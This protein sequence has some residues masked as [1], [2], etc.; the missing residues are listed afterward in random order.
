M[1]K[2]LTTLSALNAKLELRDGKLRVNAPAGV[3]TP[4]LQK[5]IARHKDALIAR[6]QA[7]PEIAEEDELPRIVPDP[8]RRFEPFP[9]NGV[10]HAYWIGRSSHIELGSVSTHVYF[11][12]ECAP[13][14]PAR[15]TAALRK[16]VAAHDMLRAVV[17]E[18][19]EQCVLRDVPEYAIDVTDVRDADAARREAELLRVRGEMAHQV[20]PSDRWPLF[21]VRL[22]QV[23]ESHSR[24]CV[25]WDFLVVDAWSMMLIFR[26]WFALYQDAAYDVPVPAL[27]FRDY[28]LAEAGLKELPAYQRSKKY[29]WDRIDALPE[30]PQL[31]VHHKI[32]LGRKHE[33]TR[34]RLR[35]DA[36][37]WDELKARGRK[38]GLT[39]TSVLLGVF[40]EVLNR[41]TKVPHYCLNL[42]LFNRLPMHDDVGGLVGDFT[43]LLALEIDGREAGSFIERAARIQSQF[44]GDFEHRQVSAVD[45]M[46]DVVKRRGLQQ[47][48]VLPVVFTSTL[49]L[50]GKRSDDASVLESFGPMGY[51]IGQTPQVW[52]D[53]QIFEIKG[54]L[55]INWDAV[56]E[57]FLPGVLDD[58]FESHR[59]L[60]D[61]L[62]ADAALWEQRD[63]LQLPE[64]QR[65]LREQ[66]D[67]TAAEVVDCCLHAPFVAQ[68][69]ATPERIAIESAAGAM[70]YG[71]LL[72]HS[73]LVAGQL[74]ERGVR[75]NELVAIVMQKGWEQIVAALGVLLAGGAYLPIDPRWP[76][77]RRGHLLEQGE[78]RI[79]LTQPALAGTLEWP[80]AVERLA[81]TPQQNLAR[82]TV[83]PSVRQATSDLAYVIFTSGSTGTPKGVMIDHRGAVNTVVH[84]NRLFG[85]TAD[86]KVLAVSD[87]GFDLSVYDI[88][89]LLAVGGTVVIPDAAQ[90]RDP[91]HWHDLITRHGVSVWNSAPPLMG[92]LV[93]EVESEPRSLAP[94]RVVMLSG[95]WIPVPLP[96]RIRR[97]SGARVISLGGATEGSIWSIYYPIGDVRS[98]WDSIPYGKALPNQHMYVLDRNLQPAPDLVRGDIYIGGIGVA[99]GYWKDPE[100]T[101]RQFL[102][103]PATGE[104]LYFTGDLGRMHRDG[105]IEFLGRE[106]SQVKLRGHRVE[107]GEI[108]ASIQSHPAVH[109]GVVQVVKE[110]GR[111]S[112]VAYVVAEAN[113]ALFESTEVPAEELQ[114]ASQRIEEA[115]SERTQSAD[116]ES[117]RVFAELWQQVD[118]VSLRSMSETLQALGIADPN[119]SAALQERVDEAVREGRVSPQYRRLIGH[120][121]AVLA[122]RGAEI[123]ADPRSAAQM[124]DD[125]QRTFGNDARVQD[126]LEHVVSSIRNQR[127]LLAGEIAPLT[128]L[129]PEGSWRIAEAL[130]QNNPAV[131]HHNQVAAAVVSAF[132]RGLGDDRAL[133]VLEI[134]AGTGGT[135]SAILPQLPPSRTEYWY[136][137]LSTYFFIAAREK[138]S[139][140]P[141]VRYAVLDA[142]KDPKAQ[143][144]Q[145]HSYDVIVAANVLHNAANLEVALTRIRELLRP[146]GLLLLL[147]GTRSTPW[148]WATVGYLETTDAYADDRGA[149]EPA[150]DVEGWSRALAKNGFGSVHAFPEAGADEELVQL[151]GAMPQHVIVAQAPATANRFRPDELSAFLRDRLPEY[152]IPQRYLLLERLPLTA[153]GKVDTAALP[154]EVASQHAPERRVVVPSSG[155]EERIL[156][157][158]RDVLGV[159]QLGVTDNFFEVGGDSLLITEVL[160]RIN[161]WQQPPLKVADL[162]SYPTI[163]SLADSIRSTTAAPDVVRPPAARNKMD[164]SSADIAIIGMAGRFPDAGNVDELWQNVAGG[165]CAVRSF[166]D[167]ELLRAGVTPEELAQEDYVRAGVVLEDLD[168]F[169]ASFFG[170]SP[171]EAE[172]MDP[173]QR[174]LLEC[175]VEALESAGYASE[176]HAGRIG[177]F[178]GKGTS[179]Y[180]LQHILQ[181]PDIVARFGLMPILNVN[182]KD[183]A[184]T[185]V[186]YKLNLT[187][188]SINV[189]TACSTSLVAVHLACQSLL[190]GECEVAL[191][192]GVSFVST[193]SRTGYKYYEG[194]ILS[195]DGYCRPFSDDANGTI[196]G[197]GAGLVVLKPLAAAL[198]DGDTIHA[199]IKGT[200]INN[201]GAQKVGFTAP[202]VLGQAEVIARAQERAG[203]SP[204]TIGLLEAHGTGTNLG[205]PIELGA[206]RKVFGGPRPDGTRCALGSVK[207]NVGHLDAASGV[208]G[209][210]KVVAALKHK[211]LPP[212][213]HAA[214]PTRKVDF[215]D[216]PFQLH[217]ELADWPANDG[218]RRAG[219][220]A[221]G[222]GGTNA[223][224]IVEEAAADIAAETDTATAPQLLPV[225]ARSEHSLRQIVRELSG[226][227][228]RRPELSLADAAF[229]L[230]VGRNAHPYRGYVVA[231]DVDGARTLLAIGSCERA[232]DVGR[233]F[234]PPPRG[235]RTILVNRTGSP[236]GGLKPRPTSPRP[237]ADGLLPPQD[238]SV[239]SQP[240]S[241]ARQPEGPRTAVAFFF[242]AT[243]AGATSA[244][245]ATQP[246]FRTAFD[247]CAGIV[248]QYTGGELRD[249]TLHFAAAYA[250]ARFWE[251]LGV[252]PAAM[253]GEG[254]GEY[255]A[256]CL[257]GVFSLPEALSLVLVREQLLRGAEPEAAAETFAKC[258]AELQRIRPSVPFVSSV[259][260][261]WITDAQAISPAYWA[262]P[263]REPSRVAD[264]VRELLALGNPVLVEIG[265]GNALSALVSRIDDGVARTV[266]TL[267][268]TSRDDAHA[269]L[270]AIGR[271]WQYG[272]EIEW[273]ALHEGARRRRV[274]LPAYAFDR[275][276][277]W[278]ERRAATVVSGAAEAAIDAELE[279]IAFDE[280]FAAADRNGRRDLRSE[281]VRP[282]NDLE[283]KLVAIWRAYLGVE[284]IGVRDDFFELGGDS[285][286]ATRIHAQ[287][288]RD[289]GVDLPLAKMFEFN[290]IRRIA[291]YT[292]ISQNPEAIDELSAEE[293]DDCLAVMEP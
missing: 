257:S 10:Q 115:A 95:D 185:L 72:A 61:A 201:D 163:Q 143:G 1:Q 206:L 41:W 180:L 109:D 240:L 16:V 111:S 153:N 101:R 52:F 208:T 74:R 230:Q 107:L 148:M 67:D 217:Q 288:R 86:D 91:R 50:D 179:L 271:L 33:F 161:Q 71:E 141:F 145:P 87:L 105:N 260:G 112:L 245:Y 210:I 102:A 181:H 202:N 128:L 189:N 59:A 90:S 66:I 68:A 198:A 136:T 34:R 197:S 268:A 23:S 63:V 225:S 286:L 262:R 244:L 152:M 127:A 20:F 212:T 173:Q 239:F 289:L 139:A 155:T 3:L 137:D 196:F 292:R 221:F 9:L 183:Y 274:P 276:R 25:S 238:R 89:G 98:D 228:G 280:E 131:R 279:S 125:M 224:V 54:D 62:A 171:R 121:Q 8:S 213:L 194:H 256:A 37:Q 190:S 184:S 116:R 215:A 290:T 56:E 108:T 94:L 259:T 132:V 70:T 170:F 35:L 237:S 200:A 73:A 45:V 55:V 29:W 241:I 253:L 124:L 96:D 30:A 42:T 242:P 100:K 223:H 191:A 27:S 160:R 220:S 15:L 49:M 78:A 261:T 278:I 282:A 158:W 258:V 142:N 233:G 229:T 85:V 84:I 154:T 277:Y 13:L 4:E 287:V 24:L 28:V 2:L 58:M 172:I 214:V 266:S 265:S 252:Q 222:V 162:F 82:L 38:A 79:A 187:G 263:L 126:F 22:I 57:V 226:E 216:S 168:R 18:N 120:W 123:A 195:P 83:A 99:L 113:G 130:Y 122:E 32:E 44:L 235:E 169:D 273:M 147:E 133:R 251:S 144:H 267:G 188:P 12:F 211:K 80:A 182:E 104:R 177:V 209:L 255:V 110:D 248:R 51:G 134:G 156:Q 250:L 270:D 272:V 60:L 81:V 88:F 165:K 69:L 227:L 157:I 65:K 17:D 21:E 178:T 26:Q 46:R 92:V 75:P 205:D 64:A 106:D 174:F 285:L 47:R 149:G 199:V 53:Y 129:F 135:S 231:A 207:S 138:F 40:S 77:L 269:I 246:R 232:G 254:V 234:S 249:D 11:E 166:T 204:D 6:L 117:L 36:R 151:L 291:L 236:G 43:N 176:K 164:V 39:P 5:E 14:D 293:L 93:D 247:E 48:A 76:A 140:H 118:A 281:Y 193:L 264:G 203:V 243:G 284:R 7:T 114:L 159:E 31:P 192:G 19:G 97:L 219:V 167:E 275:K 175:A 150:L 186:S 119:D 146:G 218:P 283:E 103:H